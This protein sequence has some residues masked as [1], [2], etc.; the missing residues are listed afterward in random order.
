MYAF[1][2]KNL[3]DSFKNMFKLLSEDNIRFTRNNNNNFCVTEPLNGTLARFPSVSLPNAWNDLPKYLQ[4]IT[5]KSMFK[6]NIKE[7]FIHQYKEHV[8]CSD[9]ACID[10][11][12]N[13]LWF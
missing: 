4:D 11:F 8:L 5:S 10:C 3:P 12:P 1:I 9:I 7:F 2:N 13:Q 6:N